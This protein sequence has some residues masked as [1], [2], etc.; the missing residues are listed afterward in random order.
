MKMVFPFKKK[1]EPMISETMN[2]SFNQD[3]IEMDDL[4]LNNRGDLVN[5]AFNKSI[6]QQVYP[7]QSPAIQQQVQQPVQQMQPIQQYQQPIQQVQQQYQPIQPRFQPKAKIIKSEETEE[8]EFV[9]VVLT[10]YSLAL[11]DCQLNQ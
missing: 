7:I 4:D 9:Y 3:D 1:K 11:G 2:P 6:Q 8:G 5:Q 10:N